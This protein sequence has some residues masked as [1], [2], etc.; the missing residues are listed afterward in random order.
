MSSLMVYVS[1][2]KR[3]VFHR[4]E[5][6]ALEGGASF[7]PRRDPKGSFYS[8]PRVTVYWNQPESVLFMEDSEFAGGRVRGWLSK[9]G[10]LRKSA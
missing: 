4:G 1:K 7:G 10:S 5:T 3:G 8:S 6:V 9:L 2:L